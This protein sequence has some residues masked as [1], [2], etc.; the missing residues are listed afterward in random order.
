MSH[1]QRA[2]KIFCLW[3]CAQRTIATLSVAPRV[4][5]PEQLLSEL[6][7]EPE[8]QTRRVRGRRTKDLNPL[9][10]QLLIKKGGKNRL[11]LLKAPPSIQAS[12][13]VCI[14]FDRSF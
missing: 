10:R 4:G 14:K 1:A 3:L 2:I 8:F 9:T 11:L 12:R 13:L 7:L 5:L 6:R